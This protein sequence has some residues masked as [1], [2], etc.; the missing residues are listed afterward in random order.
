MNTPPATY[1]Y[2]L[3]V[4]RSR[5]NPGKGMGGKPPGGPACRPEGAVNRS[6]CK[7]RSITPPLFI[8]YFLAV[9]ACLRR[10]DGLTAPLG[11]TVRVAQVSPLE[12]VLW[13]LFLTRLNLPNVFAESVRVVVMELD[14]LTRGEL[15]Q[16]IKAATDQL[17]TLPPRCVQCGDVFTPTRAH[18][19]TCSP[20]CRVA[21]HTRRAHP[22]PPEFLT[23]RPRWVLH[24]PN[25][26]PVSA[27][28]GKAASV[29]KPNTWTD[30]ETATKRLADFPGYGLGFVLTG[31]G[32][33]CYDLDNVAT[34]N[35]LTAKGL[36][37][38]SQITERVLFAELS[39]SRRGVHVWVEAETS[40]GR[41]FTKGFE[42]YTTG[43]YLTVTNHRLSV[44]ALRAGVVDNT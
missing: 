35:D 6:L 2:F 43:R 21:K 34:G 28:T 15:S 25:K 11:V 16:L 37:W 24:T 31:D 30:Y 4:A 13:W 27:V 39:P 18:A 10:F 19:L 33:G 14:K 3:G 40:R 7:T 12:A 38:V 9:L 44:D 20:R 36:E 41:V 23:S 26:L 17:A 42:R 29:T 5:A 1:P 22:H 8:G 32:I